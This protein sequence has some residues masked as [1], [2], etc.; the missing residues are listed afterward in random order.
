MLIVRGPFPYGEG[1]GVEAA[2]VW[3]HLRN[4]LNEAVTSAYGV[5]IMLRIKN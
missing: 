4:G 2:D 1:N 5:R 3:R